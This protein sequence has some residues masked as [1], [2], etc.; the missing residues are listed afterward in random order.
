VRP[1]AVFAHRIEPDHQPRGNLDRWVNLDCLSLTKNAKPADAKVGENTRLNGVPPILKAY[2]NTKEKKSLNGEKTI[3]NALKPLKPDSKM[4]IQNTIKIMNAKTEIG[5]E[6]LG[7]NENTES[8]KQN[9]KQWSLR[10][11]IA[12][13]SAVQIN[14]E[15]K[16]VDTGA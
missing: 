6:I 9:M 2:E 3:Q 8:P 7:C 4:P 13:P 10:K 14:Q 15:E 16:T 1:D 11:T 5:I 12:V